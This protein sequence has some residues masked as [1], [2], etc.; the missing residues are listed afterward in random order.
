MGLNALLRRAV[1]E[2]SIKGVSICRRTSVVSHLFFAN[3]C[4]L[5]IKWDLLAAVTRKLLIL[6]YERALGQKI[7]FQKL[8]LCCNPTMNE[9]LK[10]SISDNLQVPLV[11]NFDKYFGFPMLVGMNKKQVFGSIRDRVWQIIKGWLNHN[12]S[13]GGKDT[14]IKVV[15]KPFHLISWVFSSC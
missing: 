3:D 12:F 14:L 13:I 8:A 10:A 15:C 11:E 9:N 2:G 5:F 7:I 6:A 1:D 4:L